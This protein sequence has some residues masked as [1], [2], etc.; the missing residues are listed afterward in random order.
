M[1]TLKKVRVKLGLYFVSNQHNNSTVE[2]SRVAEKCDHNIDPRVELFKQIFAPTQKLA[3]SEKVGAFGK[4]WRLAKIDAKP[5]LAPQVGQP[6]N[7]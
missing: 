4:S 7:V 6:S 2:L 5:Q 1:L 3:P